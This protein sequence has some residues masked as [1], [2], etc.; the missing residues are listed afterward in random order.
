MPSL[1]DIYQALDG[2]SIAID[3][4]PLTASQLNEITEKLLEIE[5]I[6]K[7]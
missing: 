5:E 7:Q 2:I 1:K 4:Q 6:L 3:S